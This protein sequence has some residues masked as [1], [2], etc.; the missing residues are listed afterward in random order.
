MAQEPDN[1]SRNARGVIVGS[2]GLTT[3]QRRFVVEYVAN[4]GQQ[5]AAATVAG[6]AEPRV[7][8]YGLLRL[9]HVVAAIYAAQDMALLR[10][11]NQSI[12]V[13]GAILDSATT[14]TKD[15]IAAT[16]AVFAR[17][18]ARLKQARE[19]EAEESPLGDMGLAE[20]RDYVRHRERELRD[21]SAG[22]TTLEGK[23]KD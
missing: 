9:A 7:D 19:V 20:L 10:L 15:K 12:R 8:A 14:E 16:K 13:L 4:G 11:A 17:I 22:I 23:V 3:K 6:Y 21:V 1:I 18:D 2:K 5:T